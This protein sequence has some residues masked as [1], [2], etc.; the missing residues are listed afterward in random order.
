MYAEENSEELAATAYSDIAE[1][2]LSIGGVSDW[3]KTSNRGFF[4]ALL[5]FCP[6]RLST[7]LDGTV[8][9]IDLARMF[10]E[11]PVLVERLDHAVST[12]D[13]HDRDYV[14]HHGTEPAVLLQS[15]KIVDVSHRL[16]PKIKA[17]LQCFSQ[18]PVEPWVPQVDPSPG[19]G[20][21]FGL[22]PY[23]VLAVDA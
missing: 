19:A 12:L 22:S 20:V 15:L 21:D 3:L 1:T 8:G 6:G 5:C 4:A 10:G 17:G 11:L 2:L 14:A 13:R 7:M 9:E 16:L 23:Q 18:S